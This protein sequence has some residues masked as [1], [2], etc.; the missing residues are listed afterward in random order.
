[1]PEAVYHRLT[2]LNPLVAS[3][4]CASTFSAEKGQRLKPRLWVLRHRKTRLIYS[5]VPRAAR[6]GRLRLVG[7]MSLQIQ[8]ALEAVA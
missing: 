2:L 6:S 1:M 5:G 4:G 8:E 3:L 7:G